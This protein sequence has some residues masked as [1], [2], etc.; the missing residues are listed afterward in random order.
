MKVAEMKN[1]VLILAALLFGFS[2]GCNHGKAPEQNASKSEGTAPEVRT[3]SGGGSETTNKRSVP[4][5]NPPAPENRDL[6]SAVPPAAADQTRPHSQR[7]KQPAST[8]NQQS[9]T[10]PAKNNSSR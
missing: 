7:Q 10:P 5:Q 4:D 8:S 3:T 2:V 6:G 1:V 9:A